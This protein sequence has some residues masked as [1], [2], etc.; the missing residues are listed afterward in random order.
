MPRLRGGGEGP[1]TGRCPGRWLGSA[2]RCGRWR[3]GGG[4]AGAA[5]PGRWGGDGGGAASRPAGRGAGLR[6]RG[7]DPRGRREGGGAAEAVPLP[8]EDQVGGHDAGSLRG[9]LGEGRLHVS[10]H[11]SSSPRAGKGACPSPE[12]SSVTQAVPSG[13]PL[14]NP[15]SGPQPVCRIALCWGRVVFVLF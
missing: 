1:R 14:R 2:G 7:A 15:H 11:V 12:V 8:Q 6:G 10:L 5:G 13:G 3:P 4:E 9:L